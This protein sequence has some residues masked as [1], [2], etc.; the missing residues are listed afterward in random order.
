[1]TASL[2]RGGGPQEMAVDEF[3]EKQIRPIF[4]EKCQSCHGE[5]KARSGFRLLSRDLVL[6]GGDYGPGAVP[7]KPEES[8]IIEA[9]EYLGDLQMPPEG[10]LS[11]GEIARLKKWVAIGLPWPTHDEPANASTK[12]ALT[13]SEDTAIGQQE[14]WWSFR[15]VQRPDV[16]SVKNAAWPRSDIDR[17]ILAELEAHGITPAEPAERRT[18]IRRATFDLT[19]LPPRTEEIEAFLNDE[20]P[21]AFAKVVDHLLASTAYGERWARHWLDIARYADSIQGGN[22]EEGQS[23]KFEL[24]EA[25]KYRDWVVTSLNRDLPFDQFIVHQIAGDLLPKPDGEEVNSDGLIATGF[26][27]NGAWDYAEGDKK[28]VVA[29]I[30]D[31]QIDV[32]GKGFLGLTL[33]CARC[34]DHKFDPITHEDYYALAGIFYS[35]HV[36]TDL[37]LD[38]GPI[39]RLREPLVPA[40]YVK[41]QQ[42]EAQKLLGLERKIG[43]L[44]AQLFAR[45]SE[46]GAIAERVV[47][48]DPDGA[49][50]KLCREHETLAK[51]ALPP[52]PLAMAVGEGG[53]L[54]SLF[55]KIQDVPVHLRG[56]Y[57]R[58]GKVV[59]RRFPTVLAGEHQSPITKGSGRL[60]LA[61]WIASKDNPLT[62]RVIVNRL[63]Q[64]HFGEGIV[65]TPNNFGKHGDPPSHPALLDWLATRFIDDG[66]SLKTMHRR[67]MLSAVYQQAS[68]VSVESLALDVAN[69]WFGRMNAQRLDAEE[70]RDALLSAARSLNRGLVGGPATVDVREPRRS[71]YVQT[72]RRD[73]SNLLVLFDA[74]NPDLSTEARPVSTVVPQALFFLNDSF[75]WQQ[76]RRISQQL[77]GAVPDQLARIDEAYRRLFGRPAHDEEVRLATAFFDHA[78]AKGNKVGWVDYLHALLCSN[79]FVYID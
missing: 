30:V 55:P 43:Q 3:F 61:Q 50:V 37:G 71:L 54:Q 21:E 46:A 17:F 12:S 19:G 74:A 18:L 48:S 78:K 34:H 36:V 7:G 75:V 58:L 57:A 51:E 70:I 47:L 76:A 16:P 29:D 9:V 13:K 20:S 65:R 28:K 66:W 1:M 44:T 40:E 14:L 59:P 24:Y 69:R 5:K 63:W 79:E 33:S 26:L 38:G 31:D 45:S 72:A 8:L 56:S 60:E 52:P 53:T 64:H 32:V 10:K 68:A 49:L 77:E 11:D 6:T 15:P 23:E 39:T 62:A 2:A 42:K 73:R 41:K 22:K 25:Y 27:A 35:T 67:I 4:V